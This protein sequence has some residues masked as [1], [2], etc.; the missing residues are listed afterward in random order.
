MRLLDRAREF[1]GIEPVALETRA[2]PGDI[3]PTLEQQMLA[4]S[5]RTSRAWAIASVPTALGVPAILRAVTLISNTTGML[6]LD[7]YTR[8]ARVAPDDRP[9][10][11][12]RPN[13]LTTPRV[14]YRDTAYFIASRGEA[15]WWVAARDTDGQALSLVPVHPREV[16]VE[17][18]PRD[19]R[20]PRITW[21]GRVMANA[22]MRQ[23][24]LM[25]D[26]TGLRGIGPLQRC[27]AAVSVAV[28]AQ[29]W[30][31]N[32][33]A[34]GGYPSIVLK[35]KV[36]MTQGEADAFKASW[37][38]TPNNTPRVLTGDIEPE[39]FPADEG[40][41]Q[42]MAAREYQNGDAARMFG[43]PASMLDHSTP[44][45]SLTYQNLEGE[46][47]KWVRGGLM[48]DYLVPIEQ[49]MSDLLVRS[50]VA[51]FE[52]DGLL[53]ADVKTR[54]EVYASGITSGV[55]TVDE[56]REMEALAPGNTA[57][58]AA[59]FAP[60]A[61]M[62]P[63]LEVRAEGDAVRCSQCRRML[64]DAVTPPY[65]IRCPRCK[66][67]NE[68]GS[69]FLLEAV[70]SEPAPVVVNIQPDPAMREMVEQVRESNRLTAEALARAAEP[71]PAAVP[72]ATVTR[73]EYDKAGDVVGVRREVVA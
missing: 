60:P 73:L 37:I 39:R 15:W 45:S 22:D 58:A 24:T 16:M 61:A 49:E 25:P 9:R 11:I 4:L 40:G 28:E 46:Y 44:G 67:V 70:R 56:A 42:M 43:I 65:R 27:G 32:F 20:Y 36:D 62:P 54:Y 68:D 50:T 33:F 35:S 69:H 12:V 8:G 18:N 64:A 41:A 53:R 14:F 30:A 52:V 19:N 29:E 1:L 57:N 6:S 55:L 26:E 48:T 66:T 13:P 72:L 63:A 7:A 21:R 31:A 34:S 2:D 3:A 51:R 23:I 38:D 5:S 59:P 17:A 71:P 47:S 10:L